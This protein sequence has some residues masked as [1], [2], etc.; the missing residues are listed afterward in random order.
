MEKREAARANGQ[1]IEIV[2]VQ[3]VVLYSRQTKRRITL[4]VSRSKPNQNIH[5]HAPLV[6]SLAELDRYSHCPK[7]LGCSV[8]NP[9]SVHNSNRNVSHSRFVKSIVVYHTSLAWKN[10]RFHGSLAVVL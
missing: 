1:T 2:G 4:S 3:G 7:H 9:I 5:L 10:H 6:S 8:L